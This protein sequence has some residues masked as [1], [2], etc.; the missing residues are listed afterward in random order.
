MEW[1]FYTHTGAGSPRK[2]L[3]L[4]FN[5]SFKILK[6]F[7][8]KSENAP[9]AFGPTGQISNSIYV[10]ITNNAIPNSTNVGIMIEAEMINDNPPQITELVWYDKWEGGIG[11][12]WDSKE[13]EK[14]NKKYFNIPPKN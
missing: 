12:P 6:I 9:I 2:G 14:I 1:P 7:P 10:K 11:T 4:S 13:I 8:E 5:T 3:R